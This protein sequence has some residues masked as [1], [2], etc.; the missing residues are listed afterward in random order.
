MESEYA[1]KIALSK[2]EHDNLQRPYYWS[3]LQ[4]DKAW[5]QIGFGWEESPQ[6]CFGAAMEW[7]HEMVEND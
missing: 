7:F 4:Y 2:H 5:H 6:K 1:V 3:I